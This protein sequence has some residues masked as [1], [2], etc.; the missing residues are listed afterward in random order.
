[1]GKVPHIVVPTIR[2]EEHLREF[3]N[4]WKDEF[5]GC[6]VHL[7]FDLPEVPEWYFANDFGDLQISVYDW[8][9][10]DGDLGDKAW[11][12]PRRTDCVRSYGY[13]K[14]WQEDPLFI[15]TLDDDTKPS[16]PGHI[17]KFYQVLYGMNRAEEHFYNT[18]KDGLPAPRGTYGGLV[19]CDVAHGGWI[20]VPDYS[21]YTQAMSQSKITTSKEDFNSGTIPVGSLFSLCGMNIAWRPELTPFMY[22]GL[23]GGEYPIDRCGDI[24]CGYKLAKHKL[25]VHTGEPFVIH[26]RA[27]NVWSNLVKEENAKKM[28][29]TYIQHNFEEDVEYRDYWLKLLEAENI[30]VS[31]FEDSSVHDS[32]E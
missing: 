27:S 19:G 32:Q 13:W 22:F 9:D 31:L 20:G 30:W 8:S 10:I 3:F 11:I 24:W 4:A 16:E 23:Q 14:A 18:L 2:D 25:I 1:M 26:D 29:T 21:G 12:I 6:V 15:V 28:S 17:Q 7:I 5:K